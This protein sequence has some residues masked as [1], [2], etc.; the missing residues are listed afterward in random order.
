MLRF[1]IIS[2]AKIGRDNVVP[3]IQDAE[4]CVVTAI[5]SR[6]LARAREMADR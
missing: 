4:N 2:T 6:D 1:G 5:A 3:A